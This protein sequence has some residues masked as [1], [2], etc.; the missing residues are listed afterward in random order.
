LKAR[1]PRL[2]YAN[3]IATLA[4]FIALGGGAIAASTLGKNSVG[5][6]QLKKNSVTTPKVK[7]KAITA[8]KVKPGTLTG[9]QINSATLGTVPVATLANSIAPPEAWHPAAL[10]NGWV[11]PDVGPPSAESAGFYKDREGTVHL[12]GFARNGAVG[13]AVFHLPPG[14][15]PAAGK[16]LVEPGI[17][18]GCAGGKLPVSVVSIFGSGLPNPANEGAVFMPEA[19]TIGFDGITFRAES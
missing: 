15:R 18:L 4:L 13:K 14:Y 9:T 17:C 5:P 16:I 7:N 2:T 1:I 12:K 8:A 6:K 19:T 11:D 10:E 3:V